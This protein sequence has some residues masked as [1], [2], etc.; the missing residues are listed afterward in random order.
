M[1]EV[2]WSTVELP[3][4]MHN[5][6]ED[7]VSFLEDKQTRRVGI[8][9]MM[10]I[11]KTTIMLNLMNHEDIAKMFDIVIWLTIS[12]EWSIRK[13]QNAITE[14]LK[15]NAESNFGVKE[16]ARRISEK[17]RGK[18]CLIL[19]DEVWEFVDLQKIMGIQHS[20]E[21]KVVLASRFCDI[22]KA[23]KADELIKVIPL[24]YREAFSLFEEKVGQSIH[25]PRIQELAELVVKECGGL[26]ALIDEAAKEFKMKGKD[27]SLWR[28]GL[29]YLRR[30][31]AEGVV[32]AV[33]SFM[34]SCYKNLDD[35]KKACFQYCIL[36]PEEY[37]VHI[38]YLLECWRAEGFIESRN[39]GH[40]VLN[41]LINFSFLERC[42][43]RG[44]CVKINKM[45][46]DLA[47][48]ISSETAPSKF[49]LKPR[50]GLKEP[51]TAKEWEQASH[52]SL[53]DNQLTSLPESLDCNDL[54]TLFLQDNKEL[55]SIPR[56]F[57]K[58]MYGLRVLDLHGNG[59]S[60]L[61]SSISNLISLKA[62][63][64][65][66]CVNL[67]ELPS[68]IRGLHYLEVLDI[69][70]TKL[71]LFQIKVPLWLK[72]LRISLFNLSIHTATVR[73]LDSISALVSLE[74]FCVDDDFLKQG[75]DE[76]VENVIWEVSDLQNLT[77]LQFCL[78][79]VDSL[80]RF[81]TRSPAWKRGTS[82]TF[83]FSVG[84]QGLTCSQ[85]PEYLNAPSYNHLKLANA[86]VVDP[87]ISELL[88]RTHSF[89]LINYHGV[90]DLSDF[91]VENLDTLLAC[92]VE[93]CK[94]IETIIDVDGIEKAALQ[95]LEYLCI[96]NLR[97]LR[98]IWKGPVI[99]G[100]LYQLKTLIL[101]KCP[102][103]KKIFSN[104]MIQQ[105]HHLQQLEV[106]ECHQVEEIITD[107][108]NDRVD[109][110][111]LPRL[112][113]LVLLHLPQLRSIWVDNSL[114]WPSLRNIRIFD[115]KKLKHFPF[116]HENAARLRS[117]EGEESWWGTLI[118]QDDAMKERLQ[119]FCSLSVPL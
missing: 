93:G 69:R 17:L 23:M 81:V 72:C 39:Q 46:R 35:G 2:L 45:L 32:H 16:I 42:E 56:F 77:S 66:F 95:R 52:I 62:L 98:S 65:N 119:S 44:Y 21:S 91:V 74:E 29:K 116:S 105:L 109:P 118:W 75:W 54:L 49:L 58:S 110:A 11:G 68:G 96:N 13:L 55:L 89:A 50:R 71:N 114:E 67:K 28:D 84:F 70:G 80:K 33:I 37:N 61:P 47:L 85:L 34:K 53:M 22:C 57:F 117:I 31:E 111:S 48:A 6:V 108:E 51:P 15:I 14:Q 78:P 12:K 86:N 19:L 26:P 40:Q 107:S 4:S 82:F 9:G 101:T 102:N 76:V 90:L 97:K 27:V 36:F 38:D 64:L 3:E 106:Q 100:S 24:S 41:T 18:K 103:L 60:S 115:C 113:S 83:Q 30:W 25:F 7:V 1:D 8:W 73:Q 104:D 88:K 87:V 94:E 59:I 92:T 79:T 5:V 63:Y 20:Q 112:K 10:G 99:A 43:K